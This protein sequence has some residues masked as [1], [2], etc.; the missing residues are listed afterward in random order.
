MIAWH[1]DDCLTS[2]DGKE[3]LSEIG[4]N[5]IVEFREMKIK[6]GNNYNF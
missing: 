5:M 6:E 4:K 3:V 1:V 2:H